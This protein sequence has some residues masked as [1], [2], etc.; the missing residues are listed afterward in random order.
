MLKRML[1]SIAGFTWARRPVGYRRASPLI[2][3]NGLAEQSESWY[4]NRQ[5]WQRHFD[6]HLPALLV[7]GGPVLQQRLQRHEPIDVEFLTNRLADYLDNYVQAP[8]YDLVG[9]SLGGQLVVEFAAR[10]PQDVNHLVLI[11]PSGMG[12]EEKLPITQ[13][14]RHRD[15]RGLVAS[16]FYDKRLASPR[17]TQY[18]ERKFQSKHWRRALFETVRGT[19]SHSIRNKLPLIDRPT[20]VICGRE[21]RIVDTREIQTAVQQMPDHRLV[22]IPQCGHAPQLEHPQIVNR[23]VLDFLKDASPSSVTGEA[24]AEPVNI[25]AGGN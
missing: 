15:Y 13:G 17:V 2:L 7:Y 9:S 5:V 20:L 6:V 21:D 22:V 14:A 19:K 12:G 1:R 8:P 16:T 18:Y 4:C 25:A 10:R 24:A 3:V 23:L 11:C